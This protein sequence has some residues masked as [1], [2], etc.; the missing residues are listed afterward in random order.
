MDLDNEYTSRVKLLRS[1]YLL[2]VEV[3]IKF[4]HGFIGKS[5]P[6]KD[7]SL[8]SSAGS[9]RPAGRPCVHCER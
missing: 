2:H 8:G 4:F 3:S 9:S 5:K 7:D 6:E 1:R